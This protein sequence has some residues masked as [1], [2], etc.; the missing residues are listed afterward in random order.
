MSEI[1]KL[2]EQKRE[3]EQRI[4][5]LKHAERNAQAGRT[6]LAFQHYSGCA[7]DY[8]YIAVRCDKVM[9]E[10]S[11]VTW[12]SIIQSETRDGA[13]EQIPEIIADLQELYKKLKGE[14]K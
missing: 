7:P 1:E 4:K 11:K 8:Y 12:R 6:K 2:Q 13:I 3:I 14:D 10:P 5:E 9:L